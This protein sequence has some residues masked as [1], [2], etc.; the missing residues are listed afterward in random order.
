MKK[1]IALALVLMSVFTLMIPVFASAETAIP[2]SAMWV[3]CE[4]GRRLNVRATP[5]TSGRLLYRLDCGTRV[6]IVGMTGVPAGWAFVRSAGHDAGGFVMTKF[7]VSRQPSIYEITERSDNFRT[8][9]PFI[10]S[11]MAL[12]SQ[13]T[14]SVGLYTAP[15]VTAP[16]IRRLMAGDRL[17]VIAAGD[18]WCRVFDLA[19]GQTGYMINDYMIRL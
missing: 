9:N 2:G 1:L 17:Q 13:T 14:E 15:N 11:A 12:D 18:V 16:M 6:E 3:N 4:D 19:T 8:V 10:V 7:L 5:S